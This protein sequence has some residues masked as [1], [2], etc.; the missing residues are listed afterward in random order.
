MKNEND[1]TKRMAELKEH[2][3]YIINDQRKNHLSFQV[4]LILLKNE[5]KVLEW[6][7]EDEGK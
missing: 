6:V 5:F 4:D 7:L 2:I 3:S 1:I